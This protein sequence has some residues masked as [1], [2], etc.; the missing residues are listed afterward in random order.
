MEGFSVG[1]NEVDYVGNTMYLKAKGMPDSAMAM[2]L[3]MY[4]QVKGMAEGVRQ[5]VTAGILGQELLDR[6]RDIGKE[7][8]EVGDE[9]D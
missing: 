3:T 8:E 6:L 7:I 9:E 4:V 1:L 2:L 5:I